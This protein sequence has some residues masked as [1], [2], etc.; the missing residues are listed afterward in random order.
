MTVAC[1]NEDLDLS[2]RESGLVEPPANRGGEFRPFWR[3]QLAAGFLGFPPSAVHL[4]VK[5]LT[6]I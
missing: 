2:S 3:K 6:F 4:P 5:A 1:S